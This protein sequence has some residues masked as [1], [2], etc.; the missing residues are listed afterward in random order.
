MTKTQLFSSFK[1]IKQYKK[2]ERGIGKFVADM[3]SLISGKRQSSYFKWL[4]F[5][6]SPLFGN[7]LNVTKRENVWKRS[8]HVI[9][10]MF[11]IGVRNF[12]EWVEPPR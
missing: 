3:L 6:G 4:F 12:I 2:T 7:P 11:N 8:M 5:E 10:Q 9:L 1:K